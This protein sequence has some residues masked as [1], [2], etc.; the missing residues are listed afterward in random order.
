MGCRA[1]A[2]H[3]FHLQELISAVA[4]DYGEAK[5]LGALLQGCVV[6]LA[7]KLAGVQGETRTGSFTCKR[8]R[9]MC[10]FPPTVNMLLNKAAYFFKKVSINCP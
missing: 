5:A 6:H 3:I 1:V 8:G 2:E 10:F 9:P 4:S 7:L